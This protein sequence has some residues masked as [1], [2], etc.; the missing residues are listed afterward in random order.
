MEIWQDI[1]KLGQELEDLHKVAIIVLNWNGWRD[2]IECL[3]SI[4]KVTYPNYEVIL[5]DNGSVDDSAVRI[6]EWIIGRLEKWGTVLDFP[7]D[8]IK[9]LAK[10][11]QP[12]LRTSKLLF[13]RSVANLGFCA[14]NNLGMRIAT[15]L[16][17][18]F[19]L[20]L[21]NDTIVTP[22][23]LEPMV[24]FAMREE[25]AGLIG[26]V[27]CYADNP[28][29]I[30]F[31]G[32][33]FDRFLETHRVLDGADI[34]LLRKEEYWLSDWISGCMMLI[35][36]KVYEE[37]GGFKEDLFFWAEEWDYSLRVRHAGYVLA[38]VP[39][40]VVYH[41]VGRSAG[42]LKPI[43]Y[44]YGTRNRLI[45]K[46]IYLPWYRRWLFL[47]WFLMTRV[48]RYLQFAVQGRWDLIG[49]GVEAIRDYFLGRNGKW[50]RHVG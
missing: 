31:A 22:R 9:V 7:E 36:R 19:L 25:K 46:R 26:G 43:S 48:P 27:I 1:E 40:A 13:I 8:L 35:P 28:T 47:A 24:S 34:A 6:Q 16:D 39:D 30:W 38:V 20:I 37:V 42:V 21:N 10:P 23:F 15:E 11:I 32:G 33:K 14:G 5:L 50:A 44:Y 17:A 4:E 45:L 2:T 41:K 49:A 12:V 29:K 18:D 3:E